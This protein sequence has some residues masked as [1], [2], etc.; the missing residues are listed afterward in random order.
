[1][2]GDTR[3]LPVDPGD[4]AGLAHV[5]TASFLA[6]RV[7]PSGGFAIALAGGVALAR[8]AQTA[9]ARVGYGASLAAM[10]QTVAVMGPARIGIPLTQAVSAPML[11]RLHARGA[12]MR[13]QFVACSAIRLVDQLVATAF[14]IWIILGGLEVYA[15]T[16]DALA[17]RLPLL[18]SGE[19]AALLAT[20]VGL[21]AWTVFASAVQV[22]VYRRGLLGWPAAAASGAPPAAVPAPAAVAR[23]PRFDPRAVV[24]SAVVAFGALLISTAWPVL[25]GVG[26]WLALAW[27]TAR[28]DREPVRAGLALAAVL[29]F[30]ALAFGVVSGAGLELTLQRTVRAALLVLVATWLRAAAGEEGLREVVRRGLRRA[31]RLPSSAEA[32]AVFDRLG[33]RGG[34][35]ASGRALV[36]T[37]RHVPRRPAPLANAVLLWIA[38]EALRFAPAPTGAAPA[39]LRA[40]GSDRALVALVIAAALGTL[41]LPAT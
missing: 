19:T 26:V 14:Y 34:L 32:A 11:G 6:S 4:H 8:A 10:A 20:L 25:A 36:E 30:G 13:S 28:A 37:V 12:G 39:T 5:A 33:T 41:A 15:G 40:G 16:Y 27:A 1:M 23:R 22:A 31:R 17:G 21:L 24:L 35:A 18:G 7:A 3:E 2:T 9:G 38:V 29:A